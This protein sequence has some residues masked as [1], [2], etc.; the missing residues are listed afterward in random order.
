[1][2]LPAKAVQP[3]TPDWAVTGTAATRRNLITSICLEPDALEAH[4]RHLEAKYR[5]AEKNEARAEHYR[6]AD[7]EV[8]LVG[9]GIVARVLKAV[10]EQARA[11][12]QAVGMLRPITLYPF[13][14]TEFQRLARR[15][16]MFVV[17]EMSNGQMVEDVRLSLNGARPVEFYNRLGGNVPSAAEVFKFLQLKTA[18]SE[19]LEVIYA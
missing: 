9:Y 1:V 15:A 13:P 4:V 2:E 7:A 14:T 6:T 8:V 12:G 10:A 11:A 18:A 19:S 16:R 5:E 17:V 3:A